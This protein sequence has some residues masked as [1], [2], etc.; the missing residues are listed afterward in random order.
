M[1]QDDPSRKWFGVSAASFSESIGT[2]VKGLELTMCS[3]SHNKF[4]STSSDRDPSGRIALSVV[5]IL[6]TIRSHDPPICGLAGG[7]NIHSD[8][9]LMKLDAS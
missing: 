2:Y 1:P 7:M 8:S 3:A 6:L 5:F 4:L 9:P